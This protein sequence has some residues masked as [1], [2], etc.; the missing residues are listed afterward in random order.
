M[1][2]ISLLGISSFPN[3]INFI[4]VY[5]TWCFL[6]GLFEQIPNTSG[7]KPWNRESMEVYEFGTAI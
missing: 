3:G 4:D 5:D 1:Y 7:S 6:S 2:R